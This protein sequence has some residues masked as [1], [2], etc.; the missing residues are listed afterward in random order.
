[1]RTP[2]DGA[3]CSAPDDR[4]GRMRDIVLEHA[5]RD[6]SIQ[7]LEIGCG[8][9]ALAFQLAGALPLASVTGVDVSAANIDVA[10]SRRAAPASARVRFEQADYLRYDTRPADVIVTD[11]ALH[12][13]PGRPNVL[14]RKLGRD[15]RGGGVLVCCMAYDCLHNRLHQVM[16]R[17]LRFSRSRWIDAL[18][19]ALAQRAYGSL[20]NDALLKERI[21]YMYIPPEQYMTAAVRDVLAPSVGLR[22]ISEMNIVNMS[23]TQLKQRVTVFRKD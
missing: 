19:L 11:S 3:T 15:I 10:T 12:S 1:M 17:T 22:V 5:P 20:M 6:R 23:L 18:L 2:F 7:V 21:E 13:F 4:A 16:R 8:T 9:G 14:W